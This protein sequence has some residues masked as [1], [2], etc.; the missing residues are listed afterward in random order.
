M[1]PNASLV[2]HEP[3]LA[4][5]ISAL[6]SLLVRSVFGAGPPGGSR[7]LLCVVNVEK[8][9]VEHCL[10]QSRSPGNQIHMALGEEPVNPVEDIER[11]VGPQR[12]QIV[13]GDGLSFP[14]AL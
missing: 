2:I 7:D 8:I 11:P 3:T 5:R 9:G 4:L 1:E 14:G 6:A 10:E 13:R 12:E